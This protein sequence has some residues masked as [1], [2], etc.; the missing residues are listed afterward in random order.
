MD[1]GI[2]LI[3]AFFI[4]GMILLAPTIAAVVAE[5]WFKVKRR[6][7]EKVMAMAKEKEEA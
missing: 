7:I 2:I 6:H 1:W 5:A 3:V 4:G